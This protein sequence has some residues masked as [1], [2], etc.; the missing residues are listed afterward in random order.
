[1]KG[2]VLLVL[3]VGFF[4]FCVCVYNWRNEH[5]VDTHEQKDV[6]QNKMI[7]AQDHVISLLSEEVRKNP[8]LMNSLKKEFP[9]VDAYS[10]L[11]MEKPKK[12]EKKEEVENVPSKVLGKN[13]VN[14][15]FNVIA[16]D[17]KSSAN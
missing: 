13:N 12:D 1:M 8:V 16:D 2:W 3:L 9:E 14:E 4:G 6:V 5:N 15:V 10:I 11:H 7:A 17:F